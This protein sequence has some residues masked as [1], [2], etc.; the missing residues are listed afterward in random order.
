MFVILSGL[1]TYFSDKH[2]SAS[3]AR[4][5]QHLHLQLNAARAQSQLLLSLLQLNLYSSTMLQ[6]NLYSST[7]LLLNL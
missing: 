7:L 4:S 1:G 3:S 2:S 6:L 5:L